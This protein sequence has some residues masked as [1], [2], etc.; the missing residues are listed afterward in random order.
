[1]LRQGHGA[2]FIAFVVMIGVML[3]SS[4]M[5]TRKARS[6]AFRRHRSVYGRLQYEALVNLEAEARDEFQRSFGIE[7]ARF[8]IR[9]AM[10]QNRT[11]A[12]KVLS[13]VNV[14]KSR[15]GVRGSEVWHALVEAD[16]LWSLFG[17]RFGR[18]SFIPLGA[19][20]VLDTS[21][22]EPEVG[23]LTDVG[24]TSLSEAEVAQLKTV[25]PMALKANVDVATDEI[26]VDVPLDR[27]PDADLPQPT[28]PEWVTHIVDKRELL[29]PQ[30]SRAYVRLST[31]RIDALYERADV[32]AVITAGYF[33]QLLNSGKTDFLVRGRTI[34]RL[35]SFPDKESSLALSD[36]GRLAL[37]NLID[38]HASGARRLVRVDLPI[39]DQGLL[40]PVYDFAVLNDSAVIVAHFVSLTSSIDSVSG[41]TT[42]STYTV[43]GYL[44]WRRAD[45]QF[46]RELFEHLAESPRQLEMCAVGPTGRIL[47]GQYTP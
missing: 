21:D 45:V 28:V 37:T 25:L 19:L 35:I 26:R 4:W 5:S 2:P 18:T 10:Q 43:D 29:A 27:I 31:E 34:S 11:N 3:A 38:C 44:S 32:K 33:E 17:L 40:R 36:A 23:W 20:G 24:E 1:M 6:W 22:V 9:G 46:Y 8:G 30:H 47:E 12:Q 13:V 41:R 42:T 15:T 16:T 39:P 14:G 7:A